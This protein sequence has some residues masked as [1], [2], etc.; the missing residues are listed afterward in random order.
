M[1]ASARRAARAVAGATYGFDP[2][3][4]IQAGLPAMTEEGLYYSL[5]F[6]GLVVYEQPE[7]DLGERS[8]G[9]MM[10]LGAGVVQG[11]EGDV[12]P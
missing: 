6:P 2:L 5:R 7:T 9:G 12:W 8:T 1:R 3:R 4:R 10:D 11:P